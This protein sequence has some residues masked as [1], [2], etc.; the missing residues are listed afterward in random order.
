MEDLKESINII[1]RY[2]LIST[3]NNKMKKIFVKQS[4]VLLLLVSILFN[5]HSKED[6]PAYPAFNNSYI[7]SFVGH[8]DT[9]R[10]QDKVGIYID[11]TDKTIRRQTTSIPSYNLDK[12]YNIADGMVLEIEANSQGY[13]LNSTTSEY[14]KIIELLGDDDFKLD[15]RVG[16]DLAP[17]AILDTLSSISIT[18][19]QDYTKDYPAGSDIT[20]LFFV[21]FEH[22]YLVIKNNYKNYEGLD[23]YKFNGIVAGFPH[24]MVGGNLKTM[25]FSDRPS[26]GKSWI[27]QFLYAPDDTGVYTFNIEVTKTNGKKM[28]T[29]SKPFK[30]K[31]AN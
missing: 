31:G 28:T 20:A 25:N 26:I 29:I 27:C 3:N 2:I 18:C 7:Q 15:Y 23:A 4:V 8:Y 21:C 10:V 16:W 30:I 5:C 6:S 1:I 12:A 14:K 24:A 9:I 19:N 17:V 22:P 13:E 11:H